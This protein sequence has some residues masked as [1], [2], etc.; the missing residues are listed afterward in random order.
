MFGF[1]LADDLSGGDIQ[2]REQR[3]GAVPL[4][5]MGHRSASSRLQRQPALGSV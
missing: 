2:C 4:V 1:A 5:I 3:A